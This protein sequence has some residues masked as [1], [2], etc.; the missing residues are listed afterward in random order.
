MVIVAGARFEAIDGDQVDQRAVEFATAFSL[1]AN[2]GLAA[3]LQVRIR[4][5]WHPQDRAPNLSEA[6]EAFADK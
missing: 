4:T 2:A 5:Q 3:R 1:P 6:S